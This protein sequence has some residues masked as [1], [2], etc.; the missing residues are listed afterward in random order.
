MLG[1]TWFV[2]CFSN[3]SIFSYVSHSFQCIPVCMCTYL[4]HAVSSALQHLQTHSPRPSHKVVE[5]EREKESLIRPQSEGSFSMCVWGGPGMRC[6][7][8]CVFL[9][10]LCVC[11]SLYLLTSSDVHSSLIFFIVWNIPSCFLSTA[12][13]ASQLQNTN[14]AIYPCNFDHDWKINYSYYD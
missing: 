5:R 1:C 6:A 7:P 3:Y 9:C 2:R 8:V 4:C 11:Q 10:V 14:S 12:L 13:R